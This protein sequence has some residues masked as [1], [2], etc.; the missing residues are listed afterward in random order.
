MFLVFAHLLPKKIM[1]TQ[2]FH[3]TIGSKKMGYPSKPLPFTQW[4]PMRIPTLLV[5]IIAPRCGGQP[6]LAM[7]SSFGC[8]YE[9]VVT[10]ESVMSKDLV[11]PYGM[12]D[13]R[14]RGDD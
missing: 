10:Q 3:S 2:K 9:V 6:M 14:A 8:C 4:E 1:Q 5:G 12:L 13:D 11:C 7:M